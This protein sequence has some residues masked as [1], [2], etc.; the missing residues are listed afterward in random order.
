MRPFLMSGSRLMVSG[1]ACL[2]LGLVF[3][4]GVSAA[5]IPYY[6]ADIRVYNQVL[7]TQVI[8]L[9]ATDNVGSNLTP[10]APLVRT[11]KI[12][13]FY[14]STNQSML[15]LTGTPSVVISNVSACSATV[16]SWPST[17]LNPGAYTNF[18]VTITPTQAGA[19]FGFDISIDNDDPTKSTY[20]FSVYGQAATLPEMDM[21]YGASA[22]ADGSAQGAGSYSLGQSPSLA[23]TIK[24][25]GAGAL[26]LSGSP[27]V[28]IGNAANCTASVQTQPAGTIS[29]GQNAT[30]TVLV[31]L[32]AVGSFSF[33]VSIWNN[34]TD[35]SPYNWTVNGTTNGIADID[36]QRPAGTSIASGSTDALG[37]L[38]TGAAN[39][40]TWTVASLGT[41]ALNLTGAPLVDVT[42]MN[43]CSA[44]VTSQ[45]AASVNSGQSTTFTLSVTA[46]LAGAFSFTVSILN[47][48]AGES[49]YTVNASGNAYT[50]AP[51]IDIQRPLG[52]SLASGT[53]ENLG[54]HTIGSQ[55]GLNYSILNMGN[56]ALNLTGTPK[57]QISGAS[58]CSASVAAQPAA[59]VAQGGMTTFDVNLTVLAAA[60]F[61]FTISIANDDPNES[62]YT[63]TVQGMGAN[64]PEIDMQVG[65][66]SIANGATHFVGTQT[67][68]MTTTVTFTVANTGLA[69]L[70]LTGS[71]C[72][73]LSS[74]ANCTA[75]VLSQPNTT[76]TPAGSV[77][78]AISITPLAAGSFAVKV[79]VE[80]SDSDEGTYMVDVGGQ[81]QTVGLGGAVAGGSGGGGCTTGTSSGAFWLAALALLLATAHIVRRVRA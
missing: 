17:F 42:N 23:Y 27:H 10:Q 60:S 55:V 45:P 79:I 16:T 73:K 76:V 49:P 71:P 57:V 53:T 50:P 14:H 12:E 63:I 33:D 5:P 37:T 34:D 19:V 61:G 25:T 78:F 41:G 59:Q 13:N 48:D 32:A 40:F 7:P 29:G 20:V 70:Q 58:N 4:Q 66:A 65:G 46:A 9:Y 51:E 68:T 26:S 21:F 43:N 64:V 56:L 77:T 35:E 30:F 36:L 22:L 6:E 75:V 15:T 18:D 2:L 44:S 72:V 8:A 67:A 31:T 74:M 80:N 54:S 62:P 28:V 39:A 69:N 11:Y 1:V 52:T 24:N 3:A 38:A 47:N 81:G